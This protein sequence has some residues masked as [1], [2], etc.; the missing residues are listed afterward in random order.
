MTKKHSS[1]KRPGH[2]RSK[3]AE[4]RIASRATKATAR[5]KSD[6]ISPDKREPQPFQVVATPVWWLLQLL[7]IAGFVWSYWPVW[8]DLTILWNSIPDYSHGFLVLPLAAF[9]LWVKRDSFPGIIPRV[10][11]SGLLLIIVAGCLRCAG[12]WFYLDAVQGWSIP[13]W[14]AGYVWTFYG[15][16]AFRWA[17]PAI[18]FLVFMVPIPYTIEIMLSRPLQLVSTQISVV[19]LQCLAQPAVSEGTTILLGENTLEVEQA[20][21][22]MRI[23][24]GIAALAYAFMM[25]FRRPLWTRLMLLVSI[26]PIA[27]LANSLRIVATGLLYQLGL[28]ETAKHV[29]HDMAGWFMIPL[30]AAF[31]AL[32]LIYLDKLFPSVRTIDVESLVRRQTTRDTS[33]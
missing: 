15:F 13:V 33:Q 6:G 8:L 18:A 5:A 19:V 11:L 27:L 31:F 9:F 30:A 17:V 28:G 16:P 20:C 1:K 3:T 22:G 4:P 2:S 7:V 21:S 12:A 29:G 24:F 26:L 14:I 10:S 25:L 23:F 32:T